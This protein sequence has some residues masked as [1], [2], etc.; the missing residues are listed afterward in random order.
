MRKWKVI[1]EELY[2]FHLPT[3]RGCFAVLTMVMLH[4]RY[5]LMTVFTVTLA[6]ERGPWEMKRCCYVVSVSDQLD[7]SAQ[8]HGLACIVPSFSVHCSL[9]VVGGVREMTSCSI[10]VP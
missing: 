1:S 5:Q 4:C 7:L 10:A 8:S 2:A 9:S 3:C 6:V